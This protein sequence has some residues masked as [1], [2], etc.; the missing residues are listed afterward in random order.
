MEETPMTTEVFN[1]LMD[2]V[3]SPMLEQLRDTTSEFI[4][5]I[6]EN[7]SP[8]VSCTGNPN[9]VGATCTLWDLAGVPLTNY[10]WVYFEDAWFG[11]DSTTDMTLW[12][13]ILVA[14]IIS[15][16]NHTLVYSVWILVVGFLL[17]AYA[18]KYYGIID[19]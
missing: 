13:N 14:A 11:R 4:R 2:A 18:T 10:F 16:F 3:V 9:E 6:V 1:P 7:A 19:K 8:G 5:P 12:P 15:I 17:S